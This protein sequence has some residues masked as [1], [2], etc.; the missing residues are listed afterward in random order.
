MT[1]VRK[2]LRVGIFGGTFD[3]IHIGHLCVAHAAVVGLGLDQVRFVV[4]HIPWQKVGE[5]Q[6]AP[7][8]LRLAMVDAAVAHRG[9]FVASAIEIDRGGDSYTIDTIQAMVAAAVAADAPIEPVLVIGSDVAA[10]LDTWHRH[11]DLAKLV[12]VAI[13]DRPGDVGARPPAGWDYERIEA[14][15]VDLSSTM[16]RER[17]AAGLP[18]D[19][20]VPKDA[21]AVHRRWQAGGDAA[22]G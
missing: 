6:I 5:R 17:L 8:E 3:P 19:Y 1:G 9:D 13:I 21:L 16:L 20:L 11:A 10:G 4:A 15:L 2:P 14:P 18:V 22:D 12:S 7:S